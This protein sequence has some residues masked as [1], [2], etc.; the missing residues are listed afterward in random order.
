MNE[1]NIKIIGA[2]LAGSEAAWYLARRGAKVLLYEMRPHK[3]TPAHKSGNFAELVCSNSLRSDSELSGP[4]ILKREMRLMSSITMEAAETNSVPAGQS[5]AVDREKFSSY[6]TDKLTGHENITI[7]REEVSEIPE[8]PVILATGPLTSE[9]LI[10]ALQELIGDNFLYFYDAIAPIVDAESIDMSKAFWANRYGKGDSDD[11]LNCPMTEEEYRVF[12]RELLKAEKVPYHDFES[13]KH[14]EG[15]L[16]IEAMAERGPEVLAHGP[17]K[18][19]GLVDPRT[20]KR[21]Y[22]VVQLRKENREGTAFNIVGFQ[23][24]LTYREQERIFRLIPCLRK[25]EFLRFGSMHRNTYVNA[26]RVLDRYLRIKGSEGIF[27]AG[28]ITGVEGYIESATT[29]IIAGYY[30]FKLIEEKREPLIPPGTTATGA[31][32][33]YL[34]TP[35]DDFQPSNINFSLFD[36]LPR[37]IK[38]KKKRKEEISRRALNDFKEWLQRS[39]F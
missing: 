28:Q 25:A 21:P 34:R 11:Y 27:L 37:R 20:G 1:R 35:R 8:P 22:A 18:P 7:I 30:S 14:F 26:P 17:M 33:K 31:L 6:I 5:L 16:P 13:A 24:K 23:T 38:N 36:P 29:G 19:V 3:T 32:L 39:D 9:P 2:G 15:C 4:G 12:I 10:N